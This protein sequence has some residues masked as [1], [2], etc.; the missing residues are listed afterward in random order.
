MKRTMKH[1]RI[2]NAEAKNRTEI[3]EVSARLLKR[4]GLQYKEQASHHLYLAAEAHEKAR[5]LCSGRNWKR[6][7][8][9]R[10]SLEER[11]GAL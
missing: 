10:Q 4:H 7:E 3:A 8:A 2:A 6:H 1:Y 11:A 9:A 5:R